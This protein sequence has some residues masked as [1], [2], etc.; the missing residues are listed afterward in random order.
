MVPLKLCGVYLLTSC[1]NT[2]YIGSQMT[3]DYNT[4]HF[5]L[6]K[7]V[8]FVKITKNMYGSLLVKND[9]DTDTNIV[10]IRWLNSGTYDIDTQMLPIISYPYVKEN[11]P[12][13]TCSYSVEDNWI[14]LTDKSHQYV[15]RKNL[16]PEKKNDTLLKLFFTQLFLD[17]IIRHIG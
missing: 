12:R 9:T 13:M 11:C 2:A 15:F 5:A 3:L 16:Y 14:I 6:N 10:K 17:L 7:K 4:I 8:G 1:S